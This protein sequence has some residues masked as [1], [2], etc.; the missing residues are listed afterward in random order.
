MTTTLSTPSP[1]T[2]P[3]TDPERADLLA[4]LAKHRFFLT[5]PARGLTDEQAAARPLPSELCI[6][7]LVKHVTATERGWVG[8][9]R[10]GP[11]EMERAAGDWWAGHHMLPGD[12]LAG[13][14]DDYRAAA[15]ETTR[16]VLEL[17][18]LNATRPLPE[19]PWFAPG[20]SWSVRRVLL[21][22]IAEIA[23]HAG[24]ADM[25]REAIDGAKSMG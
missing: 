3:D 20:E 5:H 11:A 17:P 13:L 14:L 16:L 1:A 15:D 18:D 23:Q 21:H 19:A 24:H 6:G 25:I 12:T 4:T 22:L 8:F 7:G 9:V 10:G 2:A